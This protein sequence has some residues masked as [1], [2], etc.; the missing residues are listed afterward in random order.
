[1]QSHI[2][3]YSQCGFLIKFLFVSGSQIAKRGVLRQMREGG[4]SHT[5]AGLS[6]DD[7]KA[8]AQNNLFA[9]VFSCWGTPNRTDSFLSVI[10]FKILE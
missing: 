5:L 10:F 7:D 1:M 3:N 8:A 2:E 4:V 6:N 9:T